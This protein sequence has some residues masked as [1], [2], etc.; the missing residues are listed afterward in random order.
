MMKNRKNNC[1]IFKCLFPELKWYVKKWMDTFISNTL[2]QIFL[3][4]IFIFNCIKYFA[5]Y[6]NSPNFAIMQCERSECIG[7]ITTDWSST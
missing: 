7:R 4:Q 1:C 6:T 5:K 3:S 2:P